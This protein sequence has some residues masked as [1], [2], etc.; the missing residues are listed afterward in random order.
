MDDLES[1]PDSVGHGIH[2]CPQ[3][4][5]KQMCIALRGLQLRMPQQLA[6]HF[7]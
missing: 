4:R 7:Q 6:D 1:R 5:V 2:P 3:G